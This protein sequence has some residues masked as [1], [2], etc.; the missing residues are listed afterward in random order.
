MLIVVHLK[1]G[2]WRTMKKIKGP[3]CVVPNQGKMNLTY[4]LQL[5][6][7]YSNLNQLKNKILASKNPF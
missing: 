2:D 1:S 3:D 6:A 7:V 4:C 5:S